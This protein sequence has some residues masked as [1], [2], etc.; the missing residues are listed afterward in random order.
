MRKSQIFASILVNAHV[1]HDLETAEQ[2]VLNYLQHQC[3]MTQQE[4]AATNGEY[5]ESQSTNLIKAGADSFGDLCITWHN[6]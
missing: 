3:G 6:F 2:Q 5:P 4:I 1:Y